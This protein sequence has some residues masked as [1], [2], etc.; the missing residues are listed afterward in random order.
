MTSTPFLAG[1]TSP[2]VSLPELTSYLSLDGIDVPND[3]PYIWQNAVTS[4]D[5]VIGLAEIGCTDAGPIAMK[6]MEQVKGSLTDWRILNF[7]WACADGVL[8]TGANLRNEPEFD[9]WFTRFQDLQN[10]RQTN[11]KSLDH[12]LQIIVTNSGELPLDHPVFQRADLKVLIVTGGHGS[13]C[14]A[15]RGKSENVFV[16]G[17]DV[18]DLGKLMK[19]LKEDYQIQ[20]LDISTGGAFASDCLNLGLIDEVR[21]TLSGQICGR[22]NSQNQQR[23]VLFPN[24]RF[25]WVDRPAGLGNPL[26]QYLGIRAVDEH[27]VFVRGRVQYR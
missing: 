3:R 15:E 10:Y 21:Y 4:L 1:F 22:V 25:D 6:H 5:G 17:G 24:I 11:L 9:G 16:C 20:T 23:P 18:V 2:E 7:G 27:F 8:V 13:R 12:P 14:L 19:V 26:I